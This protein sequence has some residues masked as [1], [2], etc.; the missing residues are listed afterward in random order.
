M[1]SFFDEAQDACEAFEAEL[2]ALDYDYARQTQNIASTWPYDE[3]V[4]QLAIGECAKLRAH[5]EEALR[6][7]FIEPAWEYRK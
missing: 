1:S 7:L 4:R 3:R 2:M 5:T 6:S